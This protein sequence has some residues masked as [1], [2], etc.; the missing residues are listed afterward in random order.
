MYVSICLCASFIAGAWGWPAAILEEDADDVVSLLQVKV[1]TKFAKKSAA[2]AD[3]FVDKSLVT[4]GM[5]TPIAL[6]SIMALLLA[7]FRAGSKQRFSMKSNKWVGFFA[8]STKAKQKNGYA[9]FCKML[10]HPSAHALNKK[11]AGFV[12]QFPSGLKNEEAAQRVHQFLASTQEWMLSESAIF[13]DVDEQ[14]TNNVAEGL[15]KFVVSKLYPKVFAAELEDSVEDQQ[16]HTHICALSWIAFKHLSIPPVKL[17]FLSLAITELQRMDN[18]KAP[19]DKLVC[20]L[21]ACRVINEVLR[22]TITEAADPS[23]AGTLR[24]LSADDFLPLLIFTLIRGN[25]PRLHSNVE[26]ISTFRHPSRL[27]AEDAYF[28]TALQSAVQFVKDIGHEQLDVTCEEFHS[29]YAESLALCR[30]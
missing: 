3:T 18:F 27:V 2:D 12:D 9:S 15:E 23:V 28:L 4:D 25:P 6:L 20:V 13:V 21:N 26:F 1:T 10:N 16:L 14:G 7:A 29:L 19:R 11:L 30:A 22:K 5:L 24:P 17:K 8:D